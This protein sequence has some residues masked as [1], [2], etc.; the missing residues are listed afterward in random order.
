MIDILADL[1]SL[2]VS[3]GQDLQD[4]LNDASASKLLIDFDPENVARPYVIV[5]QSNFDNNYEP[6]GKTDRVD[7][8]I[9][10]CLAFADN[11]ASCVAILD[12]LEAL[13]LSYTE[14]LAPPTV[15]DKITQLD[16]DKIDAWRG[17]LNLVYYLQQSQPAFS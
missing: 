4:L 9:V 12:S 11:R 5:T 8:I 2:Y 17:T 10:Q 7:K 14:S 15:A 3:D 13:Y 6:M 1:V 16:R